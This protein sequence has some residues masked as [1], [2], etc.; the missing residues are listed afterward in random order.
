MVACFCLGL[1]DCAVRGDEVDTNAAPASTNEASSQEILRAYLQ[2]QEQLHL[3]QLA[4]EQNRQEARETAAQT[5]EALAG[6]LHV[7]E[8]A[9]EAQRTRELEAMQSSN[10]EILLVAGT[11]AAVGFLAMLLMA[12][13]Q[14]RTVTRLAD[15]SA[16]LPGS[17]ALAAPPNRPALGP[18]E[19]HA[20]TIGPAEQ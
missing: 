6:R 15:I 10:R 8:N 7:I 3:T 12:F 5:S 4:I 11:F 20:V 9:L 18:G 16:A 14:W 17:F 1:G 19:S 2:L 13:F